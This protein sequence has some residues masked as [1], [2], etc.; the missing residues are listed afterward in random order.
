MRKLL[1]QG[2]TRKTCSVLLSALWRYDAKF[3]NRQL[4]NVLHDVVWG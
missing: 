2:K 1:M 4:K 3:A